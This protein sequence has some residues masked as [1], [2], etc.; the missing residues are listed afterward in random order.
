MAC[1]SLLGRGRGVRWKR[2][3][4]RLEEAGQGGG[5]GVEEGRRLGREELP[6]VSWKRDVISNE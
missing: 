3:N 1:H 5:S 6:D 4:G 2:G